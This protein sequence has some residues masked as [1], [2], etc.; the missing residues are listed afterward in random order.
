MPRGSRRRK[1]RCRGQPRSGAGRS[2]AATARSPDGR[3][4]AFVKDYNVFVRPQDGPEVQLSKDG[5]AG[6]SYGMLDWAGDSKTLVAFR[7]EP[8]ENKEVYLVESSP[9]VGA[10]AKLR[11]RPYP[12]SGDK[13][14]GYELNLFDVAQQKQVKPA[15][16]RVDFG[17]PNLRWRKDGRRFT[18]ERYDRGHQRFRLIELDTHTAEARN[19]IDEKAQTFIWSAHT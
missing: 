1:K 17:R 3:W 15:V 16:E 13:Y 11:T 12:L 5:A 19:L 14:T 18:Y 8:G 9:S 2:A 4:T 10:R 7:I 6:N